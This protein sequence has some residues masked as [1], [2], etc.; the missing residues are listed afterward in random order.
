MTMECNATP[1]VEWSRQRLTWIARQHGAVGTQLEIRAR[2]RL[3][4]MPP[5]AGVIQ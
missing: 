4:C 1:S 5:K 3:A 2:A